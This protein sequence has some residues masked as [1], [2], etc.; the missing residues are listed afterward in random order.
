M[1]DLKGNAFKGFVFLSSSSN[2]EGEL[3]EFGIERDGNT[4]S[5]FV[6]T[7]P[8]DVIE[9]GYALSA[10]TCD[11]FDVVVDGVR[12]YSMANDKDVFRGTA[13]RVLYS[14]RGKGQRRGGVKN[15]LMQVKARD[16]DN[17][18]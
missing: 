6:L 1:V 17:G 12:R 7:A 2:N 8:G 16:F 18:E 10:G 4:V 15:S 5:C 11:F 13:K 14:A 9:L 3:Q